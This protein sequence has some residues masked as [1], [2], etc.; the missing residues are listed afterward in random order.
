M[1]IALIMTLGRRVIPMFI[2]RG[3]GYQVQLVNHK[4]IDRSSLVLLLA[5][6]IVFVFIENRQISAI[7]S[8]ALFFITTIRLFGW[9]T[10]GIWKKP[11]LWSLFVAFIFID[12]GFLL[13][14]ASNLLNIPPML[15]FHAFSY[16][17]IGIVTLGMMSRVSLGHTGRDIQSPPKV[18]TLSF[19]LLVVGAICRVFL[20]IFDMSHYATLILLSQILWAIAYLIFAI[21]YAS[22]L[23]K[24]RIDGQF[25]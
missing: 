18:L 7:I 17:G 13:F 19:I 6:F 21:A 11:L 9:H 20:P 15:A 16:G 24:P 23:I 14:A 22:I 8:L 2:E 4:W 3:V 1:I 5:F 10:P 12:V 25:G